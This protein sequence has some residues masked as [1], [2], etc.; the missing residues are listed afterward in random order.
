MFFNQGRAVRYI[1][2]LEDELVKLQNAIRKHRDQRGDDRCW[3]DDEELYKVL[4]EGYTPP[5][6]DSTVE[7][8][9]CKR[10]IACRHNPSTEYVSPEREIENLKAKIEQLENIGSKF[11]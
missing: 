2:R 6:R 9:N 1:D 8:E 11:S 10:Y 4:P 7:L 3:M 5:A